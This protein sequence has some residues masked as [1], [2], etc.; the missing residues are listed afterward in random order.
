MPR[1]RRRVAGRRYPRRKYV[2]RRKPLP[3][4][5]A[6]AARVRRMVPTNTVK[7][8]RKGITAH[9][10]NNAAGTDFATNSNWLTIGTKSAVAS[11]LPNYY[12]LPFSTT[13][14]I[15]DVYNWAE[16][17]GIAEK[18]KLNYV[19]IYAYCTST[20][21]SV[22]G[23]GQMPTLLW[24]EKGVDDEV[25]P[26]YNAFK[27]QMG[28]KRK[29]L[30]QGKT[31]VL[32]PRLVCQQPVYS[33]VGSLLTQVITKPKWLNTDTNSSNTEHYGLNGVLEDL[34]LT[35]QASAV[36][37]IKFDIEMGFSL[38]GIK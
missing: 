6:G 25:I 32:K 15:G 19:K 30:A 9:I 1:F 22:N 5:G 29:L 16:L 2:Y 26:T 14:R 4:I 12:N 10:Y 17:Q 21:A 8:V 11:S 37:D 38:R 34:L 13:F 24:D 3:L 20:T 27:E 33:G 36:I 28:I 7:I 23:F 35:P 31:A 18:V